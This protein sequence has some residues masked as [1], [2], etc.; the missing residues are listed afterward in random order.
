[1]QP[2]TGPR[3]LMLG[4]VVRFRGTVREEGKA[5]NFRAT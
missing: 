3:Q 5:Q 1:M 4:P 2:G